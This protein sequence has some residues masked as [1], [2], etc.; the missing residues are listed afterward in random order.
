ME[1]PRDIPPFTGEGG[2]GCRLDTKIHL[3]VVCEV[4]RVL[5]INIVLNANEYHY[6]IEE[7]QNTTNLYAFVMIK[8]YLVLFVT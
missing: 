1:K 4:R 5:I 7:I 6:E 2:R 8:S 3:R